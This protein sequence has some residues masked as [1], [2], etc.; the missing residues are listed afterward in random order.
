MLG[1][2][3]LSTY[4]FS[5]F[6]TLFVGSG[7]FGTGKIGTVT[8]VIGSTVTVTGV[9]G[10]GV[11]GTVSAGP[12]ANITVTGVRGTGVLDH[13]CLNVWNEVDTIDC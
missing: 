1:F 4:P 12:G 5:A 6:P 13:I 3:P 10:I 8:V 11:I 9:N 7:V 2:S